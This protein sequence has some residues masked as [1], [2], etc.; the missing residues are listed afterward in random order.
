M[1]HHTFALPPLATTTI[2]TPPV[3]GESVNVHL[4]VA[5]IFLDKIML[6]PSRQAPGTWFWS[7]V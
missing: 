6:G 4:H 3:V 5:F 1:W 7:K 2:T